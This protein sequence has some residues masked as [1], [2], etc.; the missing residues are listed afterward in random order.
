M[1]PNQWVNPQKNGGQG[2][3]AAGDYGG[4]NK[5]QQGRFQQKK[6]GPAQVESSGSNSLNY[7]DT[8]C[9][10]C[11]EPGH[12]KAACSKGACF[13]ICKAS[14]HAVDDCPVLKRPHQIGRY[15]GS[16]ANGLGFYHIE[17]PEVSVNPISST[18]NCGVVTI[19]DGEIGR[20][21]LA[22]EFSN[23]YKTNWPWQIRELGDWSYLV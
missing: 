5:N 4:R 3:Q 9:E 17:A 2:Q 22:R 19:E 6:K 18:R 23:I 16:S 12:L 8:I 21:D 11:G 15:I 7:A 14:N 13:F 20:E 1:Q 10:G